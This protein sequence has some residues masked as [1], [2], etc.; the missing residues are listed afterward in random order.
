MQYHTSKKTPV[1]TYCTVH[2]N[3]YWKWRILLRTAYGSPSIALISAGNSHT[4]LTFP[5]E[6]AVLTAA[7]TMCM[8]KSAGLEVT[9]SKIT[10]SWA[11]A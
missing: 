3:L 11:E 4:W 6:K 2:D 10:V 8:V 7:P 9:W 1:L 5:S